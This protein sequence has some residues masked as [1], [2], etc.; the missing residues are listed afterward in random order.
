MGIVISGA[1]LI[2][3]TPA[4]SWA[5]YNLSCQV[6]TP[7]EPGE[8][9]DAKTP[10]GKP[11]RYKKSYRCFRC[12][13]L[14]SPPHCQ[15]LYYVAGL[16]CTEYTGVAN[17]NANNVV[18]AVRDPYDC[19]SLEDAVH[20]TFLRKIANDPAILDGKSEYFG[21]PDPPFTELN[22]QTTGGIAPKSNYNPNQTSGLYI[23]TDQK[24]N[25]ALQVI[26]DD[27]KLRLVE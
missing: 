16:S 7:G 3:V 18:T 13:P 27:I 12:N 22:A 24:I 2:S 8:Y 25:E 5:Y 23:G 1:L 6:P 9:L 10:E 26:A 21:E 14:T 19:V 15:E 4:V 17:M 11:I 20:P